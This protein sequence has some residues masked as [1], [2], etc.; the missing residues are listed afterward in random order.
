MSRITFLDT[1]APTKTEKILD[2][3]CINENGDILHSASLDDLQ[4]FLMG[5]EYICGHNLINHDLKYLKKYF[6]NNFEEEYK[7]LDTLYLSPL[8]FPKKPY[9]KL[10]KDDKLQTDD[11]NNPLSDAKK[12]KDL[13]Y[14]EQ[15]AFNKLND[16]LKQIYYLLLNGDNH[17]K[18]FFEYL[19]FTGNGN[20]VEVLI[21]QEFGS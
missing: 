13:F 4:K 15:S 14:D 18:S 6:G 11:L 2:I 5:S 17:F 16:N 12:A 20:S 8:L 9:H 7:L 19:G 1:E 21:R 3:G 10:V